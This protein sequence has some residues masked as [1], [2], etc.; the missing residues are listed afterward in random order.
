VIASSNYRELIPTEIER[1]QVIGNQASLALQNAL[2]HE[3]LERLSVTDRLTELYNHGYFQERLE[4]E[5]GR[6]TRFDHQVSL[7]MLD[8]DDF[9]DFN[10][11]YGHPHGD[12]VLRTVS[13]VIKENLREIDVAARYGGEEF[14]VVLPETETEGARAVGERIRERVAAFPF[15]GG[16]GLPAVHKTVSLGVATFPEHADSPSALIESADQALFHAK[17]NGK[18]QVSTAEDLVEKATG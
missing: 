8:I 16:E 3:E 5:I 6:A 10:D 2:L 1:L 15:V 18:N 7:I 14:V 12:R 11:S 9:K 4:E 13:S 17:R